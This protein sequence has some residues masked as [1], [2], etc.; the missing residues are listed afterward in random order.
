MHAAARLQGP[1]QFIVAH[2]HH[3]LQA[4]ADHWLAFCADQAAALGLPFLSR[5]LHPAV[6]PQSSPSGVEAWAR[7]WRYRALADMASATGARVILTAHHAN[8]QLET[9]EIRRRR[10]SGVLGLAGMRERAPLPHA[11][12]GMRLLRPFLGIARS[13]LE[14][15]GRAEGIPWVDD[16]ANIDPR[17]TRNRV[18]R[19]VEQRV[20]ADPLALPAELAAIGLVQQAADRIRAQ[21][22]ADVQAASL[23]MI[24]DPDVT[25]RARFSWPAASRVGHQEGASQGDDA[26]PQ[27]SDGS[28]PQ[29]VQTS[30]SRVLPAWPAEGCWQL[31]RPDEGDTATDGSASPSRGQ[32]SA[33]RA[34]SRAA[35][36]RLD[37]ARRAE[38]LR[39]WLAT[40][41][42]RMPT[43]AK[44]AE[45]E[46]QL[47]LA[48][49][50]EARV[51][52]DGRWLL[53]YRDRIGLMPRL[54]PIQPAL[55]GWR[56]ENHL[57]LPAGILSFEPL[58][59]DD[60]LIAKF[61][62]SRQTGRPREFASLDP[63]RGSTAQGRAAAI[64]SAPDMS[65]VD[66]DQQGAGGEE[67][68]VL[69]SGRGGERLRLQP[70][71]PSRSLK[72]LMQEHGVPACLRAC[73]PVL[74]LR[75]RL[76]FAAPFDSVVPAAWLNPA[77]PDARQSPVSGGFVRL[78]WH[79]RPDI[80]AWL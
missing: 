35:L 64:S 36:L 9:V 42:C 8:D 6:G 43:R 11:P 26:R 56:G 27:P 57:T 17:F 55:L 45:L 72:N 44:L 54:T 46:R 25:D 13:R 31:P 47:V 16:P 78:R 14:A 2:V 75:G 29:T 1:W 21:A 28:I 77:E 58:D 4:P 12:A 18:R 53:R 51:R 48:G 24:R 66:D 63:P 67:G 5:R 41:G 34:L 50:A 69:D 61:F 20:R 52:H 32:S 59:D 37:P 22:A 70:I 23:H 68:V 80:A 33:V 7:E 40:L 60:D 19:V 3:G 39:Y 79:A 10:G 30:S 76:I 74:R 15:W 65:P 71:A 49:A 62:H 73:L 38:A